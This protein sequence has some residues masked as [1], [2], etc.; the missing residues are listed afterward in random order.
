MDFIKNI[1]IDKFHAAVV[2][3]GFNYSFGKDGT[4]DAV[5]L[6]SCLGRYGVKTII[7]PPIICG[8]V[9]VS[10]TFIRYLIENG[11][12]EEASEF[13]GR[14]FFITFPVVSGHKLGRTLGT[15]TI[16]QNFPKD[17]ILPRKGVYAVR[18]NVGEKELYGISNVGTRPTVCSE[19]NINCETHILD[20]NGD[21]VG[22]NIRVSFCKRL[23]DEIKFCSIDEL[24]RQIK[25]DIASARDYFSI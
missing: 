17:H 2:V 20:F 19:G 25:L 15:P 14:N 16:N 7:I 13:L 1:L 22:K 4:G 18:V 21:L 10:S 11:R 12:M 23:R 9:L 24:K 8:D 5:F 6:E 3:C